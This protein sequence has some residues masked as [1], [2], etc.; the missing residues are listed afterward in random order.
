MAT[1]LDR[2]V[3]TKRQ[4]VEHRKIESPLPF[5]KER[6]QA[7]PLPLNLSGALMG[8]GPRLIAETKKASPSRGLLRED[9]DPAALARAYAD[10]GAAAISVL[11]ERENF[12]GSLE[13]MELVKEALQSQGLP[14]LRKDF[15]F[16]PY[17]VH[18]ARAYGADA[19]L[20]IVAILTPECLKDLLELSR[21]LWLQA[22]VEV[23]SKE[24]IDIALT[25]G[26]EIIGIN[27]RDLRTFETDISLTE[28]LASHVPR[29]KILVSESGIHSHDDLVRLRRVGVHAVLVGEALV[30]APNPGGKVRELLNSA[31]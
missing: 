24:E 27:N 6:I 20:L 17:Q 16:D 22:L 29:G 9:Y 30:T 13:H 10:N 23:H 28:R 21:S 19:I 5:L 25:A 8:A 7:L 12:Q 4:E 2:I 26:A 1:I 3:E 11:T 31:F 18:E 14:V 15:I